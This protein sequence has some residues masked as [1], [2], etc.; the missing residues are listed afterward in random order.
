MSHFISASADLKPSSIISG[1]IYEVK[2]PSTA[3]LSK[4]FTY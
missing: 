2:A 4:G 3:K 1:D